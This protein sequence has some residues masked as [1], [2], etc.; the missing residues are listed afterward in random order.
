M[1]NGNIPAPN[2]ER[3]TNLALY[4]ALYKLDQGI[5]ERFTELIVGQNQLRRDFERH[6]EDGHPITSQAEQIKLDTKKAAIGA[7]LL[8]LLTVIVAVAGK[9]IDLAFF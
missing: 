5:S 1:D 8:G 9:I 2:G 6:R 7:G 4:E 3:V